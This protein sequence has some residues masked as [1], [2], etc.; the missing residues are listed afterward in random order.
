M[1]AKKN[2]E[3]NPNHP[4][5]KELL[6]RIKAAEDGQLNEAHTEYADLLF[7]IAML[8]SGFGLEKPADM[9]EPLERLIKEGFGL[10]RD[11]KADDIDIEISES[12]EEKTASDDDGE[13]DAE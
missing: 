12:E 4:I 1:Q 6:N 3:L 8:N 9:T 11:A 10:A 7:H 13:D 5:M 2:L